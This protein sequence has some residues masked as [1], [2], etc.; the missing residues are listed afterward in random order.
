MTRHRLVSEEPIS[1]D[2]AVRRVRASTRVL[3]TEEVALRGALGRVLAEPLSV[4]H[5]VPPFECSMVD[6]FA[7]RSED[8][9]AAGEEAPVALRVAGAVPAGTVWGNPI[10]GGTCVRLFTGSALPPGADAVVMFEWTSWDEAHAYVERPAP[11]GANVRSRGADLREGETALEAGATLRPQELGMLASIGAVRVRVGRRPR[12]ALLMTGDEL[13]GPD[14]ALRPGAIRSANQETLAAQATLAGADPIDLGIARDDPAELARAIE[15]GRG[16]DVIVT[17]GGVSVGD[18]DEVRAA[19]ERA[20]VERVFWRVAM[21]PGK[22][23]LFGTWN[24]AL[25]FGLPGNPV[26]SMVAFECFVR[27][28]LRRMQGD[29]EPERVHVPARLAAAMRGAGTRRHFAR[30]NVERRG[31][32]LVAIEVEPKGSGN[33]R[34][35]VRANGLAVVPEGTQTL[36]AGE[37]VDVLLLDGGGAPE[38]R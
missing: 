17:S 6:G 24:G 7:V 8:V 19:F 27:P 31:A 1:F 4:P 33:L 12:V 22:P 20:G 11:P 9:A 25:V 36:R 29:R 10:E 21:S 13:L 3:G 37:I 34:S 16:A 30:V 14:E 35:M 28:A 23:V 26:S 32:E 2:E 15:R 38:G 5:D 18:H